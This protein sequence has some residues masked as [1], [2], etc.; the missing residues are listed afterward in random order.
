MRW[1]NAGI[2]RSKQSTTASV[3]FHPRGCGYVFSAAIR[4]RPITAGSGTGQDGLLLAQRADMRTGL[5]WLYPLVTSIACGGGS[6]A[7]STLPT[8][9]EPDP[10]TDPTVVVERC[11]V[12]VSA[13]GSD[14]RGDG[15]KTAPFATL[16][17]ALAVAHDTGKRLYLCAGTFSDPIAL[18]R[19]TAVPGIY[20]GF[21][22]DAWS[23]GTTRAKLAPPAGIPVEVDAVMTELVFEGLD[24]QAAD[25]TT[26]GESSIAMLVRSSPNVSVRSVRLAAGRG[27]T[28]ADGSTPTP[29][30]GPASSGLQ[31][32]LTDG[33]LEQTCVCETGGSTTG[34][35]GGNSQADG[36]AGASMPSLSGLPPLNGSGGH[37]G[38][39]CISGAGGNDGATPA[40]PGVAGA[41]A[42]TLG[43]LDVQGWLPAGGGD[44]GDGQP[45]QG[46]GGRAGKAASGGGGGAC[47]GC[48]GAR[49]GGASGGGA[50][51]ALLALD[52][53]TDVAESVLVASDAGDGGF[54]GFGQPGQLGGSGMKQIDGPGGCNGGN[55]GSG[56]D[57]GGGGGGA[58]GISVGVLYMQATAPHLDDMTES[59]IVIGRAGVGGKALLPGIAGIAAN[60]KA[61]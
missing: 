49:G 32:N 57:G 31:P 30:A 61:L 19:T 26:R 43:L 18:T 22:C 14:T 48:G 11:G 7:E 40:L 12:F 25:A 15:T 16:P 56:S 54:G 52:S 44:G 58:G 28:G 29:Y 17:K 37:F 27:A 36:L 33:G 5:I 2:E 60:T 46:G 24:L 45:G 34:G 4:A 53:V 50:S 3:A 9:C 6:S 21:S 47:G 55:G 13:A 35:R 41:G 8:E 1:R 42:T 51:I 23:W 38:V 59:S 39:S 10:A 20:G